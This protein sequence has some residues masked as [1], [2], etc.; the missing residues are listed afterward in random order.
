MAKE[1]ITFESYVVACKLQEKPVIPNILDPRGKS[2]DQPDKAKMY[3]E[4][5]YSMVRM[6]E[7]ILL[8][9]H[10]YSYSQPTGV[11]PGKMWRSAHKE[12]GVMKHCL[13]WF[14]ESD[15]PDECL[16]HRIPIEIIPIA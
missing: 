9:L 1:E 6:T 3:F 4:Q 2:W 5:D 11:Y 13:H 12:N 14:S 8:L 7:K 16:V 10:D 15:N